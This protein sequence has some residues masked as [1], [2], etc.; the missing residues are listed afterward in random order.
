MKDVWS[1]LMQKLLSEIPNVNI[2][3]LTI[4]FHYALERDIRNIGWKRFQSFITMLFVNMC[5]KNKSGGYAISYTIVGFPQ[6]NLHADRKHVIN[7]AKKQK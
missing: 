7:T 5:I 3:D 2:K 6:K 4:Y 1:S